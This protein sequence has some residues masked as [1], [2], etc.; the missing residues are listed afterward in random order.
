MNNLIFT[1]PAIGS[2]DLITD[3]YVRLTAL[4]GVSAIADIN[5]Q[6]TAGRNGATVGLMSVPQRQIIVEFRIRKGVDA[7]QAMHD[8]YRIFSAMSSG[9]M[10][11]KGR[12]GSSKI[13]YI[14]KSIEIPPNAEELRGNVVLICPDPFFRAVTD[15]RAPIAGLNSMFQF[16]YLFPD[17]GFYIAKRMESLF[18]DVYND[19]EANTG[20]MIQ[21]IATAQVVNP[22]LINVATNEE[23]RL[24]F[25][26][27]AGDIV[28][29]YTETGEKKI[30]LTR[31]GVTTNIFGN[32]HYPFT[33]LQL[34]QGNNTFKY[35]ADEGAGNMNILVM[36]SAK[37]GAL[38]TNAPNAIDPRGWND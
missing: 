35:D 17:H 7:E 23:A 15:E 38:Y 32:M 34:A 25:T 13:D 26:M 16:P 31:D 30:T 29:I 20:M 33:F 1:N 21:F 36:F 22:A 28:R 12:L 5:T 9:T 27:A 2:I 11:F 4:T 18:A 3:D 6:A 8:M 19:G 24:N 14:V 37:F 10:V